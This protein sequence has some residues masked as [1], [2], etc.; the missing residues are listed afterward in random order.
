MLTFSDTRALSK[1]S[2]FRARCNCPFSELPG[3]HIQNF[4]FQGR[5]NSASLVVYIKVVNSSQNRK[6]N[7]SCMFENYTDIG[8]FIGCIVIR[9]FV[10]SLSNFLFKN[11]TRGSKADVKS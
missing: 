2:D 8:G 10:S 4:F 11:F 9:I 6:H 5:I 1:T 3:H 7:A